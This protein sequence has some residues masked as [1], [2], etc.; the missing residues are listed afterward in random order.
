MNYPI[1]PNEIRILFKLF[2]KTKEFL[3]TLKCAFSIKQRPTFFGKY[4]P[5]TCLFLHGE[6]KTEGNKTEYKTYVQA[7]LVCL[8]TSL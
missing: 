5:M 8:A 3:L 1:F 2:A 6:N 7:L 4:L